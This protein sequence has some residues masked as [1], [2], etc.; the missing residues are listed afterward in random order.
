MKAVEFRDLYTQAFYYALGRNDENSRAIVSSKEF[1]E[2][3]VRVN[4]HDGHIPALY[5]L[6][7]SMVAKAS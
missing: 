4:E 6:W 5:S 3:Y 2:E 1:A 7:R